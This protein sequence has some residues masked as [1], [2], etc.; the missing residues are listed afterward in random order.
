MPLSL[1]LPLYIALLFSLGH[2]TSHSSQLLAA[3]T[4]CAGPA[5]LVM[6]ARIAQQHLLAT[7]AGAGVLSRP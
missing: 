6:G 1:H 3:D 4:T 7:T 5:A 2:D